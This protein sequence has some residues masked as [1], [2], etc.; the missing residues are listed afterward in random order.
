MIVCRRQALPAFTLDPTPVKGFWGAERG[1]LDAGVNEL[2]AL[3]SARAHR[4]R[5]IQS[6]RGR[7]ASADQANDRAF[8]RLRGSLEAGIYNIVVGS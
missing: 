1:Q 5:R 8:G 4:M 7:R 6:A 3:G 2:T